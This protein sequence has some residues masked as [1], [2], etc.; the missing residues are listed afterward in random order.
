MICIYSQV[1]K[2]CYSQP[3]LSLSYMEQCP[4]GQCGIGPA[5]RSNV[6]PAGVAVQ[7]L[8]FQQDCTVP[9][10]F[11]TNDVAN[12]NMNMKNLWSVC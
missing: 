1:C 2:K 3:I 6:G 10:W 7:T 5:A 11:G 12:V 8:K 4:P 9:N